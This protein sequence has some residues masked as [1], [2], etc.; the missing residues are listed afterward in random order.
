[1][2]QELRGAQRAEKM[3]LHASFCGWMLEGLRPA[4]ALCE[5]ARL[6][7][8]AKCYVQVQN[9]ILDCHK[10]SCAAC[11]GHVMLLHGRRTATA[12]C[13]GNA[14]SSAMSEHAADG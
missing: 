1:M 8:L 7:L 14:I 4:Q 6:H 13:T 2:Q 5:R 3:K 11:P 10:A 12:G 9:T